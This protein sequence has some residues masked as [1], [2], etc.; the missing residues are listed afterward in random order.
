MDFCEIK[1][2][3]YVNIYVVIFATTSV[4]NRDVS[5]VNFTEMI[6]TGYIFLTVDKIELP[7]VF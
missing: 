6:F 2:S 5:S 1:M 3:K 7:L 4:I